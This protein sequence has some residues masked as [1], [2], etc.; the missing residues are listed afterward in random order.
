M[1]KTQ[2]IQV[3]NERAFCSKTKKLTIDLDLK[4]NAKERQHYVIMFAPFP[5]KNDHQ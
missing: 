1:T 2:C 4:I 3:Q 5:N